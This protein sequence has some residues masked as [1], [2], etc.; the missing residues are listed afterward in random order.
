MISA[1]LTHIGIVYLDSLLNHEEFHTF[2]GD[3]LFLVR[4][5]HTHK[6][7]PNMCV[8]MWLIYLYYICFHRIL[9]V[10]CLKTEQHGGG[11]DKLEVSIS[12]EILKLYRRVSIYI[13]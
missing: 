2:G 3:L 10:S 5:I 13:L 1:L 9:A 12:T 7:T 6:Y 11:M 4:Y 8:Y